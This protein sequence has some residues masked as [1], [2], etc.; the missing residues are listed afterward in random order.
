[1]ATQAQLRQRVYD[2]LYGTSL[3]ERPALHQINGAI[4]DSVLALEV[5]DADTAVT[6]SILEFED[7]G[8]QVYVEAIPGPEPDTTR[9]IKRARNGTTAASHSDNAVFAIDPVYTR[10]MIDDALLSCMYELQDEGI[11]LVEDHTITLVAGQNF[12]PVAIDS[13]AGQG[14]LAVYYQEDAPGLT[15][16]SLPFQYVE[17]AD[18]PFGPGIH[19]FSWGT[20]T[21]G[22]SVRMA[23]AK[24]VALLTES[25]QDPRLEEIM[26]YGAV[27]RMLAARSGARTHDPG[28]QTDRT[29]QPGQATRDASWFLGAYRRL[30]IQHR[31]TIRTET[32]RFP[33]RYR[34][35]RALRWRW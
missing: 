16:T 4:N 8:E 13:L 3:S 12:Y 30:I 20:K 26:V 17:V 28:R 21:A 24:P 1:M 33:S 14:V 34:F 10:K 19:L 15:I 5:D 35:N 11:Y 31:A 29:V 18:D 9:T 23:I 6:G 25:T 32:R 27:Y 22:E 2:H 7:T